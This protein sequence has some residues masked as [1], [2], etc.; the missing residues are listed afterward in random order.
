M[1][2][3]RKKRIYYFSFTTI[4]YLEKKENKLVFMYTYE[5]FTFP[6]YIVKT[7]MLLFLFHH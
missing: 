7:E 3:N 5:I 1:E 2:C 6:R 4:G